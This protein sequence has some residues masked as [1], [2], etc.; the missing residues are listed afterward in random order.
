MLLRPCRTLY[1]K[2][3]HQLCPF[4]LLLQLSESSLA[5]DCAAPSVVVCW[6]PLHSKQAFKRG[7]HASLFG[8]VQ[9]GHMA[10]PYSQNSETR[11]SG[12]LLQTRSTRVAATRDRSLAV[13]LRRIISLIQRRRWPHGEIAVFKGGARQRVNNG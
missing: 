3:S 9:G 11:A 5:K 8:P 2:S 1:S 10:K 4:S 12:L 7:P 6:R 13:T